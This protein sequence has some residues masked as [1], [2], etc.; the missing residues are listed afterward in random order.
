MRAAVLVQPGVESDWSTL[1]G[2]LEFTTFAPLRQWKN[3]HKRLDL[4]SPKIWTRRARVG[5]MWKSNKWLQWCEIWLM[6]LI[7]WLWSSSCRVPLGQQLRPPGVSIHLT[8]VAA[9]LPT[10]LWRQFFYSISISSGLTQWI[11]SLRIC[12][13]SGASAWM[14]E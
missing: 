13:P 14:A 5:I 4:T 10:L 3:Q 2:L 7:I 9:S 1:P 8:C 11:F 12:V 6:S